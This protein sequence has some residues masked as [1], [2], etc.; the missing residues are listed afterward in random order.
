MKHTMLRRAAVAIATA[1]FLA[2]GMTV[3]APASAA[4]GNYSCT[5]WKSKVNKWTASCTVRS[6]Q[7]RAV[8][9]CSNGKTV[10]G[11]W[12]GR[13]TWAF[14]GDCGRYFIVAQDT[15]GRN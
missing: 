12:V 15:Q 3:A 5:N 13:G 11:K 1:S 10:Y 7:A 4:G 8:T 14:G 2:G 6:G 9:D